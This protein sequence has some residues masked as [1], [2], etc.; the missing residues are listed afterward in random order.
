MFSADHPFGSMVKARA[1]LEEVFGLWRRPCPDRA[2]NAE[3]LF[4]L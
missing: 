2:R 3:K 1:F 4:R